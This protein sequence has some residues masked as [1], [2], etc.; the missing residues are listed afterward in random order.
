MSKR[1]PMP[2]PFGWFHVSYSSELAVGEAK[3]I[4]Y[5]AKDRVLF[6]TESGAVKCIDAYCPHMGAHLGYGIHEFNGNGGEVQGETIVCPFHGWKFN[7]DGECKDV[8]YAKNIPPKVKDKQCMP[9]YDV[10]E[11]NQ[12]IWVWYHPD[13]KQKPLFEVR[14]LPEAAIDSDEWGEIEN[15]RYHIGTHIQ[16]IAENG[17]DPAHFCYVHGTAH[18]PD[19]GEAVFDGYARNV[20]LTSKLDTPRGQVDGNIAFYSN[21][22]G[23]AVTTFGGICDTI[24]MGNMTPIDEE[25][26]EVNFGFLQKKVNGV[27]PAGGV[28]A[29]IKADI[30]QQLEEDRPIWQNKVYRPIPILCDGDGPIA[31]FRK[32]Y[33]KFYVEYDEVPDNLVNIKE[34]S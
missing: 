2:I 15:H 21:G 22:P 26:I 31:K 33:S 20:V 32:W 7:G 16:E 24:L 25:N 9:A 29:A 14:E 28:N 27:V 17:A 4:K 5:F 18:I 6:R 19:V 11:R 30:I 10:V 34:V 8:P 13:P 1:Y 3:P 23:Q 12:V